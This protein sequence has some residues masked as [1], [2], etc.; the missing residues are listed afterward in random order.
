MSAVVFTD[1]LPASFVSLLCLLRRR[2]GLS[3]EVADDVVRA[4]CY[5]MKYQT[6]GYVTIV[7]YVDERRNGRKRMWRANS[8][9]L[10]SEEPYLDDRR[11]GFVRFWHANGALRSSATLVHDQYHG[12]FRKWNADGV[13]VYEVTTDHNMYHGL[14][15]RYYDDG[16]LREET[17]YERGIAEYSYIHENG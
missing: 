12:V 5:M 14:K 17:K 1:A 15:R 11:H 4:R 3:R 16:S 6:Y 9:L 2:L 8:G 13:L 10:V 7:P